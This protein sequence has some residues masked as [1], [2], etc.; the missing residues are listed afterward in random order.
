VF[1]KNIFFKAICIILA[2]AFLANEVSFAAEEAR[3]CL[4][5]PLRSASISGNILQSESPVMFLLD[6]VAQSMIEGLT[7]RQARDLIR[8]TVIQRYP[9][10][11]NIRTFDWRNLSEEERPTGKVLILPF[12]K[13]GSFVFTREQYDSKIHRLKLD[14]PEGTVTVRAEGIT[15]SDRVGHTGSSSQPTDAVISLQPPAIEAPQI[16][17]PQ[18]VETPQAEEAKPKQAKFEIISERLKRLLGWLRA[19]R[20][21]PAYNRSVLIGGVVIACLTGAPMLLGMPCD[22]MYY[23]RELEERM[24][25]EQLRTDRDIEEKVKEAE[26]NLQ[27]M[28]EFLDDLS[29]TIADESRED[30]ETEVTDTEKHDIREVTIK[31]VARYV[32]SGKKDKNFEEMVSILAKELQSK[33]FTRDSV[34]K[35]EAMLKAEGVSGG[36]KKIYD[37]AGETLPIIQGSPGSGGEEGSKLTDMQKALLHNLQYMADKLGILKHH[38][39]ILLFAI[40]AGLGAYAASKYIFGFD[41]D[42]IFFGALAMSAGFGAPQMPG[43]EEDP[44]E[45]IKK[46]TNDLDEL[47]NDRKIDDTFYLSSSIAMLNDQ[48]ANEACK[49]AFIVGDPVATQGMIEATIVRKQSLTNLK[50]AKFLEVNT[51]RFIDSLAIPGQLESDL[52]KL[53]NAIKT[54]YKDERIILVLNF[55]DFFDMYKMKGGMGASL[56]FQMIEAIEAKN[57][58]VVILTNLELYERKLLK[59]KK[60]QDKFG[61]IDLKTLP[62]YDLKRIARNHVRRLNIIYKDILPDGVDIKISREDMEMALYLAQKYYPQGLPVNKFQEVLDRVITGVFTA[63][64]RLSAEVSETRKKLLK[65]AQE[66][67]SAI[68]RSAPAEEIEFLEVTI[69]RL[70]TEREA[71]AKK[72]E[73]NE[74]LLEKIKKEKRWDIS[75][76]DAAKQIAEDRGIPLRDI[77]AKE[78]DLLKEY[79]PRLKEMLIGQDTVIDET[80]KAFMRRVSIGEDKNRPIGAYLLVGPTGVGKTEFARS[81]ARHMFGAED[82]MIRIDMSEYMNPIDAQKLI[83]SPPGYVGYEQGGILTEHVSRKPYSVVLLDEIEKANP[84]VFKLLL[85]VFEEG[86][87]RD[88]KGRI[89]NFKNTIIIMTSNIGFSEQFKSEKEDAARLDEAIKYVGEEIRLCNATI[90]D[91][92]WNKLVSAI[93]KSFE[94][95]KANLA[96]H[97]MKDD[98]LEADLKEMSW[99]LS[100]N[101]QDRAMLTDR[102]PFIVQYL[103]RIKKAL[104]VSRKMNNTQAAYD[105]IAG[106]KYLADDPAEEKKAAKEVE[107]I[108][109]AGRDIY[110]SMIQSFIQQDI[111][112][113]QDVFDAYAKINE[114]LTIKSPREKVEAY[115]KYLRS[116]IRNKIMESV[117]AIFSP[118]LLNRIGLDNIISFDPL[119]KEDLAKILDIKLRGINTLLKEEGFGELTMD[120]A[121]RD[122]VLEEGYDVPNGARPMEKRALNRLVLA[123]LADRILERTLE[124]GKTIEAALVYGKIE[125]TQKEMEK[126]ENVIAHGEVIKSIKSES[127]PDETKLAEI[128]GISPTVAE[129]GTL[130]PEAPEELCKKYEID[131]E[132][133]DDIPL[134]YETDPAKIDAELAKITQKDNILKNTI[135]QLEPLMRAARN[136]QQRQAIANQLS[137]AKEVQDKLK[138]AKEILTA[139][140]AGNTQR[141]ADLQ[142]AFEDNM[143]K[144]EAD[145]RKALNNS[146]ENLSIEALRGELEDFHPSFEGVS[147]IAEALKQKRR[148]YPLILDDSLL[149]QKSVVDSFV[150]NISDGTLKG[151]DN[152]RVLRL[153]LE[154]LKDYFSLV[155]FFESRMKEIIE[156]IEEDDARKSIKT[157]I[158]IDFDDIKNELERVRINPFMLGYFLRMFKGLKTISFVMTTSR[159]SILNDDSFDHFFSLVD[160]PDADKKDILE[161]LYLFLKDHILKKSNANNGTKYDISFDA[162]NMAVKVWSQY[163]MGRDP[164][165]TIRKWFIGLINKKKQEDAQV[166]MGLRDALSDLKEELTDLAQTGHIEEDDLGREQ[167]VTEKIRQ[168]NE[169]KEMS[170]REKTLVISPDDLLDYVVRTEAAQSGAEIDKEFFTK[171]ENSTLINI[172]EA[173]GARVLNQSEAITAASRVLK[174]AQAG[175]KNKKAPIGTF[176]FAGPTGV[177]KTQL[178][179]TIAKERGMSLLRIDMTE[180]RNS[181]DLSRLIGATSGYVGYMDDMG[182]VDEG[183]LFKHMRDNPK[184]VLLFDEV[185]KADPMVLNILLQIMED[186]RFTSNKGNTVRFDKSIIILTTN[187]GMETY[188]VDENNRVVKESL[189]PEMERVMRNKGPDRD[190]KISEFK[191]KIDESVQASAKKFFRPEFLNRIDQIVVFNPLPIESLTDIVAIFL[192]ETAESFK[193]KQG[194]NLVIGRNAEERA[195]IY[196]Y[197]ADKGYQPENGARPMEQAVKKYFENELVEYLL[198]NRT[199]LSKGDTITAIFDKGR[200]W[201]ESSK[202]QA[203]VSSMPEEDRKVLKA[204]AAR[205]KDRPAEPITT[206]ELEEIFGLRTEVAM[207]MGEKLEMAG[208]SVELKNTDFLKKDAGL[209]FLKDKAWMLALYPNGVSGTGPTLVKNWIRDAVRLS[210]MANLEALVYEKEKRVIEGFYGMRRDDL[211]NQAASYIGKAGDAKETKLVWEVKDGMVNVGVVYNSRLTRFLYRTIFARSYKDDNDIGQNAPRSLQGLLKAKLALEKLGGKMSFYSEQDK[212]TLWM[213]IPIEVKPQAPPQKTYTREEIDALKS[214]LIKRDGSGEIMYDVID[215]DVLLKFTGIAQYETDDNVLDFLLSLANQYAGKV[216]ADSVLLEAEQV[217]VQASSA[218]SPAYFYTTA[219]KQVLNYLSMALCSLA[220]TGLK[221]KALSVLEELASDENETIRQIAQNNIKNYKQML[222]KNAQTS[223]AKPATSVRDIMDALGYKDYPLGTYKVYEAEPIEKNGSY[224]TIKEEAMF[225]N[226]AFQYNVVY[227]HKS[228]T[229]PSALTQI[230]FAYTPSPSQNK[231]QFYG[232]GGVKGE[233]AGPDL[234]FQIDNSGD[235]PRF[236]IPAHIYANLVGQGAEE[237]LKA[238]HVE[239][240]APQPQPVVAAAAD[241]ALDIAKSLG[242]P[243]YGGPYELRGDSNDIPPDCKSKRHFSV[244]ISQNRANIYYTEELIRLAGEGAE[245]VK[246]SKWKLSCK[247]DLNELECEWSTRVPAGS[248]DSGGFRIFQAK[249]PLLQQMSFQTSFYKIGSAPQYQSIDIKVTPEIYEFFRSQPGGEDLV[250]KLNMIP[251]YVPPEPAPTEQTRSQRTINE[252]ADDIALRYGVTEKKKDSF[253]FV[254]KPAS[255]ADL[256]NNGYSLEKGW[257]KYNKDQIEIHLQVRYKDLEDGKPGVDTDIIRYNKSKGTLAWIARGVTQQKGSCKFFDVEA[258]GQKDMRLRITLSKEDY[259]SVPQYL[260]ETGVFEVVALDEPALAPTS[261][262][263]AAGKQLSEEEIKVA[264][265]E[266]V[267]KFVVVFKSHVNA[268]L[269]P[270]NNILE[271]EY[272]SNKR[273]LERLIKDAVPNVLEEFLRRIKE[274]P[275]GI[276][277]DTGRY[278]YPDSRYWSRYIRR[279][280]SVR[281]KSAPAI[282]PAP[283]PLPVPLTSF[284]YRA[285]ASLGFGASAAAAQPLVKGPVNKGT[286]IEVTIPEL[287]EEL[288]MQAIGIG[289]REIKD[290]VRKDEDL[291]ISEF[292]KQNPETFKDIIRHLNERQ[293]PGSGE[294]IVRTVSLEIGSDQNRN[295]CNMTVDI[296]WG[297]G[298]DSIKFEIKGYEE[299]SY[300]TLGTPIIGFSSTLNC[301]EIR[302]K[303]DPSQFEGQAV[304]ASY[305]REEINALKSQLIKKEGASEIEVIDRDVLKKLTSIAQTETDDYVL[306]FFISLTSRYAGLIAANSMLPEGVQMR[307]G[308]INV[309]EL[310]IK[311]KESILDA[312]SAALYAL[313]YLTGKKKA[314]DAFKA[315][316]NH[317]NES[318]RKIAQDV[319]QR[320][321][322]CKKPAAAAPREESKEP[323]KPHIRWMIRRDMPEVLDIE[324]KSF[325]DSWD[326]DDFM[327]DLRQRCVIGMVAEH[328]EKIVGFM[329]YELNKTDIHILNFAVHPDHRFRGIGNAMAQKLK[330]KLG[331]RRDKIFLEVRKSGRDTQLFF[332]KIGFQAARMLSAFYK[333][334][335]EDAILMEYK[336]KPDEG[337]NTLTQ[338]GA[339]VQ[340]PNEVSGSGRKQPTPDEIAKNCGY[341]NANADIWVLYEKDEL[342]KGEEEHILF[343]TIQNKNIGVYKIK[344]PDDGQPLYRF[345]YDPLKKQLFYY[346]PNSNFDYRIPAECSYFNIKKIDKTHAIVEINGKAYDELKDRGAK[347]VFKNISFES[348]PGP[349]ASSSDPAAVGR[350]GIPTKD[351]IA[352]L[353]ASF[354]QRVAQEEPNVEPALRKIEELSPYFVQSLFYAILYGNAEQREGRIDASKSGN[355]KSGDIV[356]WFALDQDGKSVYKFGRVDA[357]SALAIKVTEFLLIDA[358]LKTAATLNDRP[359]TW[360]Y[361]GNTITRV[362]TVNQALGLML[363]ESVRGAMNTLREQFVYDLTPVKQAGPSSE[364]A[365]VELVQIARELKEAMEVRDEDAVKA[366]ASKIKQLPYGSEVENW[367]KLFDVAGRKTKIEDIAPGSLFYFFSGKKWELPRKKDHVFCYQRTDDTTTEHFD[368]NDG[369]VDWQERPGTIV[370]PLNRYTQVGDI[371]VLDPDATAPAADEDVIKSLCDVIKPGIDEKVLKA[372]IETLGILGKNNRGAAIYVSS[373]ATGMGYGDDVRESAIRELVKIAVGNEDAIRSLTLI[374]GNES[375]PDVDNQVIETLGK[376]GIGNKAAIEKLSKIVD[377]AIQVTPGGYLI[378]IRALGNIASESDEN[379]GAA[380]TTVARSSKPASERIA[381]AE[382]LDK[383]NPGN[384]VAKTVLKIFAEDRSN[385]AVRMQAKLA[386]AR[387][388]LRNQDDIAEADPESLLAI[389]ADESENP[390]VRNRARQI[391]RSQV[392]ALSE[393]ALRM[394]LSEM[395]SG[396][397]PE[398][399]IAAAR[400]LALLQRNKEKAIKN[401][402]GFGLEG[403]GA[404]A[405]IKFKAI[406][407]LSDLSDE[408]SVLLEPVAAAAISNFKEWGRERREAVITLLEKLIGDK[409]VSSDKL[410]ALEVFVKNGT[411]QNS[412]EDTT[413]ASRLLWIL[414][415]NDP[416]RTVCRVAIAGN[417]AK[418][419]IT[420]RRLLERP[421]DMSIAAFNELKEL[422]G[423]LISLKGLR[424][425]VRQFLEEIFVKMRQGA[426]GN[427]LAELK[428]ALV[429]SALI[430]VAPDSK[431]AAGFLIEYLKT[432][433]KDKDIAEAIKLECIEGLAKAAKSMRRPSEA[434]EARVQQ[435]VA[436]PIGRKQ[437]TIEEMM[438]NCSRDKYDDWTVLMKSAEETGDLQ[439]E[440]IIDFTD[441]AIA[442]FQYRSSDSGAG[443]PYQLVYKPADKKLEYVRTDSRANNIPYTNDNLYFNI[444]KID[445]THAVIEINESA[446]RELEEKGAK[447]TFENISIVIVPDTPDEEWDTFVVPAQ[448]GCSINRAVLPLTPQA[449]FLSPAKATIPSSS[450]IRMAGA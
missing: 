324:K 370:V 36:L 228:Q 225:L 212:T 336:Y 312:L 449:T 78:D 415:E 64:D 282:E 157:V 223:T 168:A 358:A 353:Y 430:Q 119:S 288:L 151:F 89:A 183:I 409:T 34:G 281:V 447:L 167:V 216:A 315:L 428:A 208:S 189:Y 105:Y 407:T 9:D 133:Q 161:N 305:T 233:Y 237:I 356:C 245:L 307:I 270:Y 241:I 236:L 191:K 54:L 102:Q 340:N 79:V 204:I 226:N 96:R 333:D 414:A 182:E 17:T 390:V 323:T 327:E 275:S 25:R 222:L 194:F 442:V 322:N 413:Y 23:Y 69:D 261:E 308:G 283:E 344:R 401:L 195:A 339:P 215:E 165:E 391:L 362:L 269:S 30:F 234:V 55:Q 128:M 52:R 367:Q 160:I 380:L 316:A 253:T 301:S 422:L 152:T 199:K 159:E 329:I 22:R 138:A 351:E 384:I 232:V 38:H 309:N 412:F 292:F 267:E 319:Q 134:V 92:A 355:L 408:I 240:M 297:V 3:S 347:F 354:L 173:L 350:Q 214:Q 209:A 107:K 227:T 252:M 184:T 86:E 387:V 141:A 304:P 153:K 206:E 110:R 61:V 83:G 371:Y 303:I 258:V 207:G 179:K 8:E 70:M 373:V 291:P 111:V 294:R 394:L 145:A 300:L 116:N 21:S 186:G 406:E 357:I 148:N 404:D 118:E 302:I 65:S 71:A 53:T 172:E 450:L 32:K 163:L 185:E 290:S 85:Q 63:G 149:M 144:E 427:K 403:P 57:I 202:T 213:T 97:G 201:F 91:P 229:L 242:L 28:G 285:G 156:A 361:F 101:P 289:G 244:D 166:D 374:V 74:K 448:T 59:E 127:G 51:A 396:K 432:D 49:N 114:I 246:E 205:L 66:L 341:A 169:Y 286:W 164:I 429:A 106:V 266:L 103:T 10:D 360:N 250:A 299:V 44:A 7:E 33:V 435:P 37:K 273:N 4:A 155:G 363:P 393:P 174:I 187:I 43:Q 378:A 277:G 256:E 348:V 411:A 126:K 190:K 147:R 158:V 330:S 135:D 29:D 423:C 433:I 60:L 419:T 366:I 334:T 349:L 326:E 178:A 124:K 130:Q 217:V 274:P 77:L 395:D 93:K 88:G 197:L 369:N 257:V 235:L 90:A 313:G 146:F 345:V 251:G 264:A 392:F 365:A 94:E 13:G 143:K 31:S 398:I 343:G 440:E 287:S 224:T 443:W 386:L 265:E 87:L 382:S 314:S 6:T 170:K 104:E 321:R 320:Y 131:I 381:A 306:N 247:L 410:K 375:S 108:L 67:H 278:Y 171:D 431:D 310:L 441:K 255:D 249:A 421:E 263:A 20:Q 41:C 325:E 99:I 18:D 203:Q 14:F 188:R 331:P 239:A 24:R 243:G 46:Y 175:L 372:V 200:I 424:S 231:I 383:M 346:E 311:A 388:I 136:D 180:Y 219:H 35:V 444:I 129:S 210:K 254:Y 230:G 80:Y 260:K 193:N 437:P 221:T 445:A 68:A 26:G 332:K 337:S 338:E 1:S 439:Y 109:R 295:K 418:L 248:R 72:I 27:E 279:E 220:Y 379:A 139:R 75:L 368:I 150:K 42:P 82:A 364:P 425:L 117:K 176:I 272:E 39:H 181:E 298:G 81:L 211:E 56:Y 142:K 62:E 113:T 16:E 271:E 137:E 95:L 11:K 352:G 125:F 140:K 76:E 58:S 284:G 359:A 198:H 402:I 177:G 259:D 280:I 154:S 192:K 377:G 45:I 98:E 335:D 416:L 218:P 121:A 420:L 5:A 40:T 400:F 196:K 122:K 120:Q 48:V 389:F 112:V 376:I 317:K 50:N 12:V 405:P 100:D 84:A 123:P 262:P 47:A 399:R 132:E 446:Y 162:M 296:G 15:P 436:A 73:E 2:I 238:T 385:E 293:V 397:T 342:G 318:I 268:I 115:M 19:L 276:I 426:A 417:F 328:D 438:K 434:P